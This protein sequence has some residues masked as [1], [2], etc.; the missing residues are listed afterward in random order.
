MMWIKK[1]L[2]MQL[3]ETLYKLLSFLKILGIAQWVR[4]LA[5]KADG[6]KLSFKHHYM[7]DTL[8]HVKLVDIKS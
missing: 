7:C 8:H 5:T 1:I 6:L 4:V 3:C 2:Y